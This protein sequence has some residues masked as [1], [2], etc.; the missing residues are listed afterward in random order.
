MRKVLLGFAVL[1]LVSMGLAQPFVHSN[2]WRADAASSK[3]GGAI[4]LGVLSGSRTFNPFVTG[5]QDVIFDRSFYSVP[6]ITRDP[7]T[8]Q[9]I[10]YAAE[11]FTQSAD[12]LTVDVT[13]REG[14]KWSDGESVTADD[15]LFY[16]T[17]VI[18]EAVGS[19]RAS[20]W[21]IGDDLV[22]VEKTGDM[23]LRF[24][25]P[26]ADREAFA[27]VATYPAPDHILGEIYRSGGAEALKAAWGT[28]IDVS[29]TVWAG[30]W[31]PTNYSADE[32]YVFQRNPYFGEWNVDE[33]GNALPYLDT[34]NYVVADLDAQLNLYIAG[35]LDIYGPHN[36][37]AVGV[38]A[39]AINN[40]EIDATVLE[41]LYPQAGTTFYVF[42]WNKISEPVKQSYFQNPDFRRAMSH[43]TPREA[44]VDL[45]YGGAASPA[46]SPV[47]PSFVYWYPE[48]PKAYAYDPE[49]ALSLLAGIGFSQKN[50]DG[51]LTD[52]DGNVLEFK[53]TT[54]AGNSN[55]ENEIQII[56]DTMREYGVNV[57]NEALEF[58][59][60][61]EQLLSTG[62]D[63]PFD[64]ILIGFGAS[65][66]DWPFFEGIFGCTGQF[67]M[68]N[69]SGDCINA[70]ELLVA[71]LVQNG[72]GTIDDEAARQIG[73]EIMDNFADLQPIIYT[74]S[75]GIHAS[76]LNRVGGEM[77]DA[78]FS[79]FNGT[80]DLV[81]TYLK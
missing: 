30:P 9:W 38:V 47:G 62:D 43:L 70:Q 48:N 15:F 64:A 31:V 59:L 61:V 75:V 81:T 2:S 76:W 51:W 1:A 35:E 18:D 28:E 32:R 44:I 20:D 69:Q 3:S 77:P 74:T 16:Y 33:A 21:F 49:A 7:E 58:G 25:Y 23:S 53:L 27:T 55:R 24:T 19:P 54:N 10:P 63:R 73:Y 56:D 36:L 50:A 67:H 11:S 60:L 57:E 45:V 37:D 12:G 26:R 8:R 71:K 39:Q 29:Q 14:I 80:R 52:A 6:L 40:G 65:T 42:N 72:R 4:T 79:P 5:E 17:A 22:L 46:Y 66:E 78:L 13:I 41:N 68:W 34:I